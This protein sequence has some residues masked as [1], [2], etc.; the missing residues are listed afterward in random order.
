ME[1]G[2]DPTA[3]RRLAAHAL[4]PALAPLAMT[5]LAFTPVTLFGCVNRG[6]IAVALAL[7]SLLGAAVAT[8]LALKLRR[9]DPD[10]ARHWIVTGLLLLLPTLL[11]LGPLG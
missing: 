10:A 11:L 8:G 5:A 7:T 6:L 2:P 3:A 1:P 9:I 4:L